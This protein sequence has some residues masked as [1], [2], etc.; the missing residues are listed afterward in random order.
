MFVCTSALFAQD[1]APSAP[2]N[3]QTEDAAD[4]IGEQP[5][6]DQPPTIDTIDPAILEAYD[7]LI[8]PDAST[9]DRRA[10]AQALVDTDDALAIESVITALRAEPAVA[11][12]IVDAIRA[13]PENPDHLLPKLLGLLN[14]ESPE[15]R[16]H[17]IRA[18]GRWITQTP[19]GAL[20]GRMSAEPFLSAPE[21]RLIAQQLRECLALSYT[22]GPQSDEPSAWAAWWETQR[23]LDTGAWA[24]AIA[25]RQRVLAKENAGAVE[26]TERALRAAYRQLYALLPE[27][28]R[29]AF[30]ADLLRS[31]RP[32]VREL[33]HDIALESI[34]N[35]RTL[36]DGVR[37]AALA[38][39]SESEPTLRR[40][41]AELLD[42][43]GL[44]EDVDNARVAVS[45][46][47]AERDPIA[48]GALLRLV[49]REHA[50]RT[51]ASV[52]PCVAWLEAE[53]PA[54]DA[55]LGAGLALSRDGLLGVTDTRA[56]AVA[57]TRAL[58]AG[59]TPLRVR[60]VGAVGDRDLLVPL[61]DAQTDIAMGAATALA[62][63]PAYLDALVAAAQ[64]HEQ[65]FATVASALA[66]HA[67][68][69]GTLPLMLTL[70]APD[71]DEK[72]AAASTLVRAMSPEEQLLAANALA[73]PS[74]VVAYLPHSG[75]PAFYAADDEPDERTASRLG[76]TAA[77]VRARLTLR[78][79]EGALTALDAIPA[80]LRTDDTES[81]RAH[82]LLW[83]GRLDAA[84]ALQSER[85]GIPASIWLDALRDAIDLAHASTI[86]TTASE[87]FGPA[88]TEQER[89][90]LGSLVSRLADAQ[91]SEP[92]SPGVLRPAGS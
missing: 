15:A 1:S 20:I 5:P 13:T 78:E 68:T 54:L 35:A 85:P 65:L 21:V 34:L 61:L 36:G 30:I 89:A 4:A 42:R 43:L 56:L 77:L 90:R 28:Q 27:D 23:T 71:A 32:R 53:G 64:T 88:L 9:D 49:A 86:A 83:L 25:E 39:A 24:L 58:G 46:L 82:A 62:P 74:D 29:D 87:L 51:P 40:R 7:R 45:W 31:D 2:I 91:P 55:A 6:T 92:P 11:S 17:A 63:D 73:S 41:S 48:A 59:P 12:I 52:E 3:P 66:Q 69:A 22:D 47:G 8:D 10:G 33:G 44:G 81:A 18:L 26:H 16:T 67:P 19:V 75:T 57:S 84:R 14:H 50:M 38:G 79:P 76:V 80:E 70:P 72:R 60:V 37:V